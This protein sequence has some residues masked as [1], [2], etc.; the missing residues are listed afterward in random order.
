MAV[1]SNKD[2]GESS[3]AARFQ[4]VNRETL[5]NGAQC[6]QSVVFIRFVFELNICFPTIRVE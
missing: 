2:K 3:W 1:A 5:Q 6:D 4:K